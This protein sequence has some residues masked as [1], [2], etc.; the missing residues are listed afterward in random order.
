MR[1]ADVSRPTQLNT[2]INVVSLISDDAAHDHFHD[3][4]P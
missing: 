3:H 1:V 4:R 2:E